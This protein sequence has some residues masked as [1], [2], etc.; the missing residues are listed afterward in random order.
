[1]YRKLAEIAGQYPKKGS[2]VYIEGRIRARKWQDQSGAERYYTE[3]EAS[4]MTMLGSKAGSTLPATFTPSKEYS[5]SNGVGAGKASKEPEWLRGD[6]DILSFYA[7]V[8][9]NDSATKLPR[10]S[11]KTGY[12]RHNAVGLQ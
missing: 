7:F 2:P 11:L 10:S 9:C 3:I 4:E 5:W 8:K 6:H 1:M 12:M